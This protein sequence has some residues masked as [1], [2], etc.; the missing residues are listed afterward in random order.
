LAVGKG[1]ALSLGKRG[2]IAMGQT[3]RVL[4]VDNAPE[5]LAILA[6]LFEQQGFE[7]VVA[8]SGEEALLNFEKSVARNKPFDLISLDI[9]MPDIQGPELA[10]ELRDRG[11]TGPMV[12]FSAMA[13]FSMKKKT[14]D[15]GISAYFS[16]KVLSA[17]LIKAIRDRYCSE[18]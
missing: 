16:K 15:H 7:A 9:N 5:I 17:E 4:I 3:L 11:Y 2:E 8:K 10:S 6:E 14:L 12:A 13:T 1:A 18:T